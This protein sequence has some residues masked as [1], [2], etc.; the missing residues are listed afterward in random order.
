MLLHR[1]LFRLALDSL[2]RRFRIEEQQTSAQVPQ[3]N[4]GQNILGQPNHSDLRVVS[5]RDRLPADQLEDTELR[6]FRLEGDVCLLHHL[7]D[8]GHCASNRLHCKASEK[9]Q[10]TEEQEVQEGIWIAVLRPEDQRWQEDS[11]H[12]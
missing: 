7:S 12:A 4:E 5:D 1:L 6:D 2:G 11:F 9:L 3:S 8:L 10:Q